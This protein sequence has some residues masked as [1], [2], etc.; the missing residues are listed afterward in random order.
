VIEDS[1][2]NMPVCAWMTGEYGIEGVYLGVMVE[3]GAGGVRRV[4]ES[5]I[6]DE[7]KAALVAASEAVR[8]K[9]ADLDDLDL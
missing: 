9:V 1:G 7:E 3:V 8:V 6:T 5:P 4:I 2:K